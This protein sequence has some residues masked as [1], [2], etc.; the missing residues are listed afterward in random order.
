[1]NQL[2]QGG[3]RIVSLPH[4]YG[5]RMSDQAQVIDTLSKRELEVAA[6]YADG[7]SYK[8]IALNLGISPTTVR[9]HLRTVYG[10]LNVTSKIALAQTLADP[11]QTVG[12]RSDHEGLA[13]E[14]ALGL[15][16]AIRRERAMARVL[17]IISQSGANVDEVID[18]VLEQALE[19]C[20][21]EFG[22]LM[23]HHGDYTFT[24]MRSRGISKSFA[25]WLSSQGLFDPGPDT[26]VGRAARSLKPVSIADVGGEGV[27]WSDNPLRMATVEFGRARSLAAI[28]MTAGGRL[29]GVFS[30]YRLRVHPF[31]DR[32]LELAQAFADQAAIAIENSRQFRAMEA[33]LEEAAATREI[34]EAINNASDDEAPVFDA[35]LRNAARICDSPS[36][37]L[38]LADAAR[39]HYCRVA[40][41]GEPM[42]SFRVGEMM[43]LNQPNDLPT[44]IRE[45]VLRHI[46]DLPRR[47]ARREGSWR[48]C[49]HP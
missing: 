24:E 36:A 3:C 29:I 49:A 20:E 18:E 19:I 39:R 13:A 44:A 10:K 34:L 17:R 40:S 6:A 42:R 11:E 41:W 23:E 46:P 22:I 35:I 38:E 25:E 30:V 32:A 7:Q 14:L 8:E 27:N 43:P 28:P 4:L 21:A 1:M 2:M 12:Q 9:S 45:G 31:N 33:R 26:A 47:A 15:D 5:D 48:W 37:R 16:E